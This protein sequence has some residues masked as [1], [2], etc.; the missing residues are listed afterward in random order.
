MI[1]VA[2]EIPN[3]SGYSNVADQSTTGDATAPAAVADL[4]VTGFDR[5]LDHRAV[6]GAGRQRV[7][8]YGHELRRATPPPRSP[9]PTGAPRSGRPGSRRPAAGTQQ[10]STIG[11]LGGSRAYYVA[12]KTTDDAGN[13]SLISN[14]VNGTTAD[15]VAPARIRDLSQR[16]GDAAELLAFAANPERGAPVTFTVSG[17]Q[18]RR[19]APAAAPCVGARLR[20]AGRGCGGAAPAAGLADTITLTWTAPGDDWAAGRAATYERLRFSE[21]GRPRRHGVM[22]EQRLDGRRHPAPVIG[23]HARELLDVR[24]SPPARPTTSSSAPP[25][26]WGTGRF[27]QRPPAPAGVGAAPWRRPTRSPRSW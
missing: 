22:V 4:T 15:T 5:H 13:V 21:P 1:R 14:V 24:G 20:M 18:D 10:S 3:W 19:R 23:G 8:R 11:G 7:D 9:P 17:F 2:D 25:T 12:I 26:R 16:D 27:L 6:D